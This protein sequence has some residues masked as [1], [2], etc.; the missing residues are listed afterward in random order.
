MRMN[1]YEFDFVTDSAHKKNIAR[2]A[3]STRTHCGKRGHVKFPSDY[4]TKKEIKAMSGAVIEYASLKNPMSWEEFKALPDDL[5]KEYITSIRERFGAP[6]G[7]IAE[8]FGICNKTLSLYLTDLKCGAGRGSGRG[9]W[10]KEEF[11]AWV[12]GADL[13]ANVAPV[14]EEAATEAENTNDSSNLS[15]NRPQCGSSEKIRAVPTDGR[16]LFECPADQAL[17]MLGLV[18]GNT[19]VRL[20]VS[21]DV[22]TEEDVKE[23]VF[24][25]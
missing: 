9:K 6:D 20:V 13:N 23:D 25:G 4:L 7:H 1:D 8:M 18:L 3:R 17:N 2:S 10:K 11:Y 5:K 16:M 15:D 12:S 19:K 21:W 24:V 22:V 14:V